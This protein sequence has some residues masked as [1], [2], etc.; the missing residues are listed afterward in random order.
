MKK[1]A[2]LLLILF[3]C[4]LIA[5]EG[6]RYLIVA[7]DSFVPAALPLAYWK[8]SKGMLAKVV[9]TSETGT[10][11][12]SICSYIQDAWNNWEIPPEFVLLLGDPV[13][14]PRLNYN[15][16]NYYGDMTGDYLMEI[17]VG[18]FPAKTVRDCSTFVT[19]VLA[20]ENPSS[21]IDTLRFY[22]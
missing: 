19:K 16:D 5:E 17:P 6:A 15:D 18:R 8:T 3:C 14:I 20:Y 7:P 4:Q 9:P 10:D 13:H 12:G 21:D 11:T 1:G 2:V 22:K